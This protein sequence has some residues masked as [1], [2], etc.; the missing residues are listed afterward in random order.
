MFLSRELSEVY[1]CLSCHNNYKF[2][3]W[4]WL[5]LKLLLCSQSIF[6]RKKNTRAIIWF[7]CKAENAARAYIL[8]TMHVRIYNNAFWINKLPFSFGGLLVHSKL[9]LYTFCIFCVYEWHKLSDL[10]DQQRYHCYSGSIWSSFFLCYILCVCACEFFFCFCCCCWTVQAAAL[11]FI[12]LIFSPTKHFYFRIYT[13]SIQI[14]RPT[15]KNISIQCRKSIA[16][17]D[18]VNETWEQF[19]I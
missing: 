16:S 3:C 19:E 11:F 5:L 10:C 6:Q 15:K 2:T 14:A 9:I 13:S 8:W 17:V 1:T 18:R 12:F 7:W 4:F